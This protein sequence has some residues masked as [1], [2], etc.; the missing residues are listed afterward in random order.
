MP[1]RWGAYGARER[2]LTVDATVGKVEGLSVGSWGGRAGMREVG[3]GRASRG[4]VARRRIPSAAGTWGLGGVY[5]AAR[6][7]ASLPPTLHAP[8]WW[9]SVSPPRAA[10]AGEDTRS[11]QRGA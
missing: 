5:E 4:D 2:R 8:R 3:R 6:P 11:H 7:R 10:F 9:L 1:R